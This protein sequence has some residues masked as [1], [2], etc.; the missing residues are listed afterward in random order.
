VFDEG[1][2]EP[3]TLP[4][5]ARWMGNRARI[6]FQQNKL[7]S[8]RLDM[9]THMPDLKSQPLEVELSLNGER[10]SSFSVLRN[11]WFE[12]CAGVPETLADADQFELELRA[13]R[14]WQP[15]SVTEVREDRDDRELSI[16]VCNIEVS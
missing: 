4:P 13:S 9:T 12:L 1:W 6:N 8:I 16:A 15:R 10:L 7:S 14:T 3:N 5:V 2:Y 11:G